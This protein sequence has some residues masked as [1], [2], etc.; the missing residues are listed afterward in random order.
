MDHIDIDRIQVSPMHYIGGKRV[1]DAASFDDFCPIDGR[2]IGKVAAG[3]REHCEAAIEAAQVAFPGWAALGPHKRRE[4]LFRFA[5]EIRARGE[6]LA[7]V[8][9]EDN[10]MLLARLKGVCTEN[11]SAGVVV[12]KST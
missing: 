8:E 5:A 7:R 1:S 11:L 10:G 2:P 9:S 4:I 12:V 6:Q 3:S